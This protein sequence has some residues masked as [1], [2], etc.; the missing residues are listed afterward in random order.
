MRPGTRLGSRV[1]A[2]VN[3]EDPIGKQRAGGRAL[4]KDGKVRNHGLLLTI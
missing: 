3:A 2:I 1:L 4:Y